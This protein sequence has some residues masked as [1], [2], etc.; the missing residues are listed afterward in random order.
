[1]KK[2]RLWDMRQTQSKIWVLLTPVQGSWKCTM[3]RL[4]LLCFLILEFAFFFLSLFFHRWSRVSASRSEVKTQ[5]SGTSLVV[6][7]L[8][9]QLSLQGARFLFLVWE[10]R[11]WELPG[12]N[13]K[14]NKHTHTKTQ[15]PSNANKEVTDNTNERQTV[16]C[17]GWDGMVGTVTNWRLMPFLK[18]RD[19]APAH[20]IHKEMRATGF[21]KPSSF[22]R[23]LSNP[24]FS[25]DF[26]FCK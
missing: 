15:Q 10:L 16:R 14:T 24:D 12:Q 26:P 21:V 17:Y 19:L 13:T 18:K 11:S 7:W 25:H 1:M 8:G 3:I 2:R 20:C 23:E 9:L 5:M 4:Q 22:L 6:Q